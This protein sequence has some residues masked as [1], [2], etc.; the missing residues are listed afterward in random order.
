[1]TGRWNPSGRLPVSWPVEAGQIPIFYGQRPTGRPAD[2]AQHY[3]AKYLDLPVEPR[4]PFG[5]GL[6]YSRFVL[7]GLAAEPAELRAGGEL[8]VEVEVRNDGPAPG[9]E[10]L[11]LF[12]RDPVAGI[13]RPLLE[14]KSM[15]KITL[16][17]GER[18]R[19]HFR[20]AAAE[21]AYLGPDLA[22]RLEPG[23]IELLVGRTAARQD[24]LKASIRVTD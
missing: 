19:V 14:L 22:P 18:G 5:H 2:P 6:S 15:A 13:A 16:G 7:G 21:L 4:F 9:E 3:S 11:L 24:L 8:S 17:P 1:L 12:V 23:V 10:T 20:L